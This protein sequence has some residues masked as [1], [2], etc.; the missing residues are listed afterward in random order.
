MIFKSNVNLNYHI[1][2]GE[3][4][5]LEETCMPRVHHNVPKC[6][7]PANPHLT[8]VIGYGRPLLF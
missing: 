3:G 1:F 8:S 4:K 7:K 2:R 6:V 5:Y